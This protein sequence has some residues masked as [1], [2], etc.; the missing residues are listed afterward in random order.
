MNSVE[1]FLAYA[2]HLEKEAAD[3][4][5]ELADVM[6]S[7]GNREAGTLFRRLSHYSTLHLADARARAGF[8]DMPEIK[9]EDFVWPDLESPERA[10]IW[11]ADPMIGREEA[12]E[13][14]LSAEQ[15]GLAYY[16]SVLDATDDPEIMAMAAEFVKE[17]SE[18]VAELKKWIAA[19]QAGGLLPVDR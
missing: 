5:G 19:H 4:F 18:H 1:E 10:A 12:L 3:R 14:A 16:Q 2:I 9:L 15:A 17:E 8:H 13:I 7:C 11:A 6:E